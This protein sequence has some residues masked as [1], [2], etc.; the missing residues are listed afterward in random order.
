M[1][2]L[3]IDSD[4]IKKINLIHSKECE[5]QPVTTENNRLIASNT[6]RAAYYYEFIRNV[7]LSATGY[8]TSLNAISS[9]L[10]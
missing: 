10:L 5:F 2:E 8:E 4:P 6:Q 3:I 7:E 1:R 9:E